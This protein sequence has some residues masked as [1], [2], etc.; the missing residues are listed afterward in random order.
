[1]MNRAIPTIELSGTSYDFLK[2]LGVS[3][4]ERNVKFLSFFGFYEVNFKCEPSKASDLEAFI[5][6]NFVLKKDFFSFSINSNQQSEVNIFANQ[7]FNYNQIS[8][9]SQISIQDNINN[10]NLAIITDD[11]L[12]LETSKLLF[13]VIDKKKAEKIFIFTNYLNRPIGKVLTHLL[14]RLD[15][16]P[17]L[18]S[19]AGLFIAI[20][21]SCLVST[22][23]YSY[24]IIGVVLYQLSA[25]LD[26]ADGP[27]ARLK[28][29]GSSFGGWLDTVFDKVVKFILYIAI[30]TGLYNF[31]DEQIYLYLS[32][33]LLFGNSMTHIVDFTH[34]MYFK[35]KHIEASTINSFVFKN[36]FNSDL[37]ILGFA[38]FA[39]ALNLQTLYLIILTIYFNFL[40]V[41]KIYRTYL[42]KLDN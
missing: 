39:I 29:L 20:I 22:G 33:A 2:L 25:S 19:C 4:L 31:T 10:L 26:C 40:W 41:I 6:N 21:A 37:N 38:C 12:F 35:S 24:S 17:N 3:L 9:D 5:K 16:T 11:K 1:M 42:N 32:I 13:S 36:I 18:I 28:Y 15:I 23:N 27:V 34:K 14:L 7:V 30:G 8:I